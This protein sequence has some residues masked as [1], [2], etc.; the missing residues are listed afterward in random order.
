MSSTKYQ[1]SRVKVPNTKY[2]RAPPPHWPA[3]NKKVQH[4]GSAV[5][6]HAPRIFAW[7]DPF[8]TPTSPHPLMYNHVALPRGLFVV[9]SDQALIKARM[10]MESK[11]LDHV[12]ISPPMDQTMIWESGPNH[13]RGRDG[14]LILPCW[15]I[16]LDISDRL[17]MPT[18][19]HVSWWCYSCVVVR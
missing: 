18:N 6:P 15:F 16:I 2:C 17:I 10:T 9:R 5:S 13:L 8:L 12:V 14:V 7:A 3:L 19:G 4:P 1:E 11:L